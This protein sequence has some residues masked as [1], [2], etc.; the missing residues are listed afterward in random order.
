MRCWTERFL[1]LRVVLSSALLT[2]AGCA[3]A[4]PDPTDGETVG[5]WDAHSH[6]SWYGEAALDSLVRYGVVGVRDVGGDALQLRQWRD[7]ITRG[8][9]R[10]PRSF[11]AG[12]VIDGPKK[13]TKFCVIVRTADEGRRAVDSLAELGV[14]FIKTHNGMSP[15]VYFAVIRAAHARHLK[16]ASHLTRGVPVWVAADSGLDS[17]EHAAESMLSSPLYAGYARTIEEAKAWWRSPAG[18][19][20]LVRLGRQHIVVDP[21]LVT[22]RGVAMSYPPGAERDAWLNTFRFL[23]ELT[24]RMHR[25]GIVLLAGS[26]FVAPGELVVPG[27]SLLEEIRLLEES[28]LTHREAL[29]AA[30]INVVRWLEKR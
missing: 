26:D 16:V 2:H 11:F 6:L 29:D 3:R 15:E 30:S 19:T 5:L 1:A 25:A 7:D 10:G 4:A 21:T 17:F 14:N 9:R 23:E 28:G 18:D 8:E 24:G 22:Y 13:S 12:P 27:R 20:M